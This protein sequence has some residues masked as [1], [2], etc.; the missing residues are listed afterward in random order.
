MKTQIARFSP[1]Q[2]AKV[3]AV[4]M[5]I[6]SLLFFVP[7]TLVFWFAAP[8]TAAPGGPPVLMF[9]L[10]PLM[11]LVLG[12]MSVVIGCAIYNVMFRF[13]GGIE[14]DTEVGSVGEARSL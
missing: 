1:H 8:Q 5:A 14:F 6:A 2:N 13:I 9:L 12:Y 11:Y 4:L 10:L 7:F 3:F